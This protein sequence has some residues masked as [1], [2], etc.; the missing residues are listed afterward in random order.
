MPATPAT[1]R[2]WRRSRRATAARSGATSSSHACCSG[3]ARASIACSRSCFRTPETASGSSPTRRIAPCGS[4][5]SRR[6]SG[7]SRCWRKRAPT[8]TPVPVCPRLAL[9]L[10]D[11]GD[12]DVILERLRGLG[13]RVLKTSV[14][15]QRAKLIQ[16]T[17]SEG[18]RALR[19]VRDHAGES[20]D[21]C[22][23][24]PDHFPHFSPNSRA[25]GC[26]DLQSRRARNARR[27]CRSLHPVADRPRLSGS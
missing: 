22:E 6:R 8:R 14:D 5:G 13:G 25:T 23:S 26:G 9:V 12:M 17:L 4:S 27:S 15:D 1:A 3:R 21:L 7:R 19:P 18:Y 2:R 16:Q 10:D 24:A 11:A 20:F